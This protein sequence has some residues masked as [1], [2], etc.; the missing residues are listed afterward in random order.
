M[1]EPDPEF[2]NHGEKLKVLMLVTEDWYFQ[3]HRADLANTLMGTGFDIFVGANIN[4]LEAVTHNRSV[5]ITHIPFRRGAGSMLHDIRTS[6]SV[7]NL[8][9]RSKPDIV[10]SVAIKPIIISLVS[11]FLFPRI[12][13]VN[14]FSGM[15][16]IFTSDSARSGAYFRLV[17]FLL[18]L[19][20]K[21]RNC[22]ALVQNTDDAEFLTSNKFSFPDRSRLIAGSGI[23]LRPEAANN[24]GDNARRPLNIVLPAR[25]LRDKGVEEF[26]EAAKHLASN[27]S[28]V[29]VLV[30]GVDPENPASLTESELK[31]FAAR[32]NVQWWGKQ[33]DMD[34]VY[35]QADI[36]CLPSYRE[37]LPKAL[38]E[39]ATYGIPLVS[40]DVPGC[41]EICVQGVSG[42]LVAPKDP[43]A[44]ACALANL[45]DDSALREQYG[46]GAL[47]LV[48]E[49]FSLDKIV[50]QTS[51]FY[52]EL[53]GC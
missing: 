34:A 26:V 30:G 22:W 41:R 50:A 39:A 45:V 6:L 49:K 25:M 5:R 28:C 40:T 17:R 2:K 14:A 38:L 48:Q 7:V 15:G 36:V 53:A 43:T 29:F 18:R 35:R 21:R 46:R 4:N 51:A 19:I 8:I 10:H 32:P 1:T 20:A 33:K 12:K 37:G 24:V 16:Y 27:N 13:F 11:I 44:L 31:E 42:L 9:R 23:K 3:S 47:R 52:H